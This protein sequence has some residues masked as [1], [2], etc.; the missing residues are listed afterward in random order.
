VNVRTQAALDRGNLVVD[1]YDLGPRNNATLISRS[2]YLLNQGTT[3]A[4]FD[5]YGNDW[6]LEKGHRL[7]VL[8]TSSNAE[9]WTHVPTNQ[10]I[11]VTKAQ[12]TLSYL[13]C[14]RPRHIQGRSSIFLD[15]YKQN[16][17]FPVA[18][19]TIAS[20]T[21]AGFPVPA[22]LKSCGS[23]PGGGRGGG[24]NPGG[25]GDDDGGDDAAGGVAQS[26]SK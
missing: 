24:G 10:P 23:N 9:W 14:A 21:R 17:P 13:R 1:T 3:N 19:G 5:L 20:A 2:A 22:A 18:P 25:G 8:I 16:A 15:D 7:G 6:I 4:S 12:I 11:T 26:S